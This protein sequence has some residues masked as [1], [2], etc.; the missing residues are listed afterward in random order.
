[1]QK[2][3]KKE[4]DFLSLILTVIMT[5]ISLIIA[6][7]IIVKTVHPVDLNSEI[8]NLFAVNLE[9]FQPEPTEKFL[10]LSWMFLTPLLLLCWFF[11]F[12]KCIIK[13]IENSIKLEKILN[14]TILFSFIS[15]LT[16]FILGLISTPTYFYI[17]H[18]FMKY[19]II[20]SASLLS[21]VLAVIL[22]Y[23]KDIISDKKIK[24]VGEI[25]SY[26]VILT[27]PIIAIFSIYNLTYDFAYIYHFNSVFHAASQVF[28][29]KEI[30]FDFTNIY[31][32]YPHFLNPIFQV[33]GLSVFKF[34][35]VMS[36]LLIIS[37]FSLF[38]FLK[39]SINN[40]YLAYIGYIAVAFISY[41][42]SK[43]FQFI[44]VYFQYAPIRLLF[45]AISIFLSWKYFNTRVRENA[46][47]SEKSIFSEPD[48]RKVRSNKGGVR[49]LFCFDTRSWKMREKLNFS[50][51]STKNQILYYISF[52]LY[53]I[54]ILWN[55]D[56]GLV[57]FISWILALIYQE[58][59]E[60]L[61]IKMVFKNILKHLSI[62]ALS[63]IIVF[64][65]YAINMKL[66]YGHFPDYRKLFIY[67]EIFYKYGYYMLP[68]RVI[69][70]WN[71]V[72]L[73]YII[74]LAIAV[75]AL[76][77]HNA[78]PIEKSIFYISILGF[79]LFSYFQGRSHDANLNMV[80]YCALLLLIIFTDQVLCNEEFSKIK[81][82]PSI[83]AIATTSL[84]FLIFCNLAL[85][86]EYPSIINFAKEKFTLIATK[87][88]NIITQ[89]IEFLK[90][91]TKPKEKVLILSYHSGIYYSELK[92]DNPLKRQNVL[93]FLTKD[94]YE[95]V[96][97]F[98]KTNKDTKVVIDSAY[99]LLKQS[100]YKNTIFE[101]LFNQKRNIKQN[102]TS[103]I[104]IFY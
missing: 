65:G 2:N 71:L 74:G 67:Q 61:S 31:G 30:L 14:I 39:E 87:K 101:I 57:V 41:F 27:F 1:M 100:K 3:Y 55:I 48:L 29:G 24:I 102:Q 56:T 12:N 11:F 34:T 40:K 75:R 33:I 98:I 45:P 8:T 47:F 92:V 17:L 7:V 83:K 95:T 42:F 52:F 76:F 93:D 96:Y 6:S 85:I 84:S 16:L 20:I 22:I 64:L 66:G 18:L 58:V 26:L 37:F 80:S 91:N 32:L 5:V 43:P 60:N 77:K 89:N 49:R 19:R 28:L 70:L 62:G 35:I 4:K 82:I 36:L 97:N 25:F 53:S 15:I 88:P 90:A 99:K 9:D 78:S 54:A 46:D 68:M 50:A 51:S 13:K 81:S 72:I 38:K 73:S 44:D 23:K 104:A 10:Y 86:A 63:L 69:H 94:D 59:V 21:F 79:G 103:T